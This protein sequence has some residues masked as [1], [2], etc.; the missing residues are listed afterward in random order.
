MSGSHQLRH[1]TL[2]TH[3]GV[4]GV[5]RLVRQGRE[6]ILH[7]QA[8]GRRGGKVQHGGIQR[9]QGVHHTQHH[10]HCTP[11]NTP[12]ASCPAPRHE[13]TFTSGLGRRA[14]GRRLR[15]G[16]RVR[17]AVV[18][19]QV[20]TR[21][22]ECS[23][24]G[25]TSLHHRLTAGALSPACAQAA[26]A[27]VVLTATRRRRSQHPRHPH[28]RR[29]RR[30]P[31]SAPSASCD[32]GAHGG[33]RPRYPEGDSAAAHSTRRPL[34]AAAAHP[35][36]PPRRRQVGARHPRRFA[37]RSTTERCCDGDGGGGEEGQWSCGRWWW[38]ARLSVGRKRAVNCR[39]AALERARPRTSAVV[40]PV[41]RSLASTGEQLP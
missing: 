35:A 4:H 5:E 2:C 37:E 8:D 13:R 39:G 36:A 41:E 28:P 15:G 23:T 16:R 9:R 33:G 26:G 40:L 18:S 6:Q 30:R 31:S 24:A 29:R 20:R 7:L 3:H 25:R 14:T 12:P 1:G 32:G 27:G 34:D 38:K 21:G 10:V 11:N 22:G 17:E 19:V